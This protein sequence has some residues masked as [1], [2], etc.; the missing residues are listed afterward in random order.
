MMKYFL[1]MVCVVFIGMVSSSSLYAENELAVQIARDSV[2]VTVGFTGAS[3][4]LF[5]NRRDKDSIV[6]I[7]IEGPTKDVTLWEKARVLGTWVNRHYVTYHDIPSY[8]HVAISEENI[9]EKT[10]AL[11][12]QHTVGHD[13]LFSGA[14]IK[15]SNSVDDITRF[16][17]AFLTEKQGAGAYFQ[18]YAQFIFINENFFRV[19]FAVPPS[20]PIGD[21][22]I[23]SY[24]IKD[25]TL[26]EREVT[27]LKVEQVG[28]NAFLFEAAQK[29]SVIYALFC[30]S[31]A[32]FSGWLV[33]VL[34]VRP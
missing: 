31:F 16:T 10:K 2:D 23:R 4:E 27:Y 26:A 15:K 30:I 24:L 3:I 8:Y 12:A 1:V 22:K 28:M 6:A 7:V 33:S 18:D 34:R 13:G 20:A 17:E 5:G 32:M 25:G 14:D 9:D 11:L 21:Y 19:S 29:Y